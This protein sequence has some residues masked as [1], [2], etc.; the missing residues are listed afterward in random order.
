MKLRVIFMGSPDFAVPTLEALAERHE[1]VAVVAQPDRPA[2]RGRKLTAPPVKTSALARQIPVLQP[3]RVK[4]DSFREELVAL[5]ADVAVIAA[6]GRILPAAVLDTPRL[7]SY[8]VHASLLPR[9]RGAAPIQWS[10]IHGDEQTGVTIM[11]MDAGMDTGDIALQRTVPISDTDTGGSLSQTLARL[12]ADA[13]L[14]ALERLASGALPLTPQN[15]AQATQAPMLQK[16]D[17][18]LDWRLS[19]RLVSCRARG[20][21]PW[22]GA[23]AH[24]RSDERDEHD[25]HKPRLVKL[26]DPAVTNGAGVS[27][28][29]LGLDDHGLVVACGEGAVSFAE[30]QL[31]GRKRLPARAVLAGRALEPGDRLG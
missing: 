31:P 19:A 20:V 14:E 8:N 22:P 21:D 25:E 27:G 15:H 28:E 13:L 30:L 2:G 17:G 1:V 29:I 26:F 9:G 6:Y 18:R 5:A 12:G 7:G 24:L 23:H 3:T 10:I 11:K 4:T 16:A